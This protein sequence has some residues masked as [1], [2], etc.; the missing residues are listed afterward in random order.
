ML[1]P[2]A[3]ILQVSYMILDMVS[4]VTHAVGNCVKR[5]VVIV[6]S[7]IFFQTPVSTVNSLGNF[8][9]ITRW[10]NIWLCNSR[11]QLSVEFL[12]IFVSI[13]ILMNLWVCASL[14]QALHLLL[15]ECTFIQ[16]PSGWSLN[17][18]LHDLYC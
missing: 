12:K 16:E 1:I 4:P 18:R 10:L 7:V 17:Q 8:F 5:V 14:L 15:P 2:F 9:M 6:S 13:K 11:P 3:W